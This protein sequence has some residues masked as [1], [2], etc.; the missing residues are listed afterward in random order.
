M[1]V[2]VQ[3]MDFYGF[4]QNRRIYWQATLFSKISNQI[5]KGSDAS[6]RNSLYFPSIEKCFFIIIIFL[7]L[8]FFSVA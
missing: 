8:I 2:K 7:I 1:N 4:E 6:I 5:L 3:K